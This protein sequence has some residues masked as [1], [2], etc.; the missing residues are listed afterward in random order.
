MGKITTHILDTA[1]GKPAAG[2]QIILRRAGSDKILTDV[3][4]NADGRCDNPLLMGEALTPGHYQIDFH[5]GAYFAATNF[6]TT[7]AS[8]GGIAFLNVVPVA[9]GINDAEANY[10]IPLLISPYGYST[11]RGS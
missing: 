9:F 8:P 7:G 11:Y 5:V 2:I 3:K 4:T 10:H 1:S 6:T